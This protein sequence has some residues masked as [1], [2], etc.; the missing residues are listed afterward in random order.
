MSLDPTARPI[1]DEIQP[2][3]RIQST[4]SFEYGTFVGFNS[5]GH[6]E[7][8]FAADPPSFIDTLARED[9]VEVDPA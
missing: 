2:G 5:H 9:A 3:A 1:S 7:A 8:R 4:N 6:V